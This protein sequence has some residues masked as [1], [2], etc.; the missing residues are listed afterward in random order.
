MLD[1]ERVHDE[2]RA[3][4]AAAAR[5]VAS[6]ESNED[7]NASCCAPGQATDVWG[8]ILYSDDD[9]AGLPDAARLA[10]LGCGNPIAA[11][12]SRYEKA[13]G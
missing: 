6:A 7:V 11:C 5:L 12:Q 8:E 1:Q 9:R 13:Y 2:V 10:S 3:H 4:Y